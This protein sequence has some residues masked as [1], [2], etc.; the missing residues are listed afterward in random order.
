MDYEHVSMNCKKKK[1]KR[2]KQF[3][4]DSSLSNFE[5]DYRTAILDLLLVLEVSAIV[6]ASFW[7]II[8]RV[9]PSGIFQRIFLVNLGLA[10]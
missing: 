7:W 10:F 9:N 4:S 1:K 3:S 8:E 6:E 2:A 5:Y